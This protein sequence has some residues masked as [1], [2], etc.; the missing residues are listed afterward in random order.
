MSLAVVDRD[1]AWAAFLDEPLRRA[2][3]PCMRLTTGAA[4]FRKIRRADLGAL[5][6]DTSIDDYPPAVALP[7][8]RELFPALRIILTAGTMTHSLVE[9][10][11]QSPP[12][13]VAVKPVHPAAFLSIVSNALGRPIVDA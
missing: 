2:G 4:L 12:F 10:L 5:I 1:P 9:V 13:H 11:R 6:L 8:L 3:V 7:M